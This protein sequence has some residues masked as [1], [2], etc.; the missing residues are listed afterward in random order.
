MAKRCEPVKAKAMARHC[1]WREQGELPLRACS[2]GDHV[3][4]Q[5]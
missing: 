1:G 3:R 5:A 4:V 2:R